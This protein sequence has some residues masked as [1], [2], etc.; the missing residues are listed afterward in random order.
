MVPAG[1]QATSLNLPLQLDFGKRTAAVQS[2]RE[3]FYSQRSQAEAAPLLA[4]LKRQ[5]LA[6]A[7]ICCSAAVHSLTA[8][9][10]NSAMMQPLTFDARAEV[11][12]AYL[13]C[14]LDAALPLA[15]QREILKTGKPFELTREIESD[16]SPFLPSTAN[17]CARFITDAISLFQNRQ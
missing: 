2:A 15:K 4:G 9:S 12:S 3:S 1:R 5:S 13:V 10:A 11:R 14:T 17:E 6:C 16:H 7:L 8:L